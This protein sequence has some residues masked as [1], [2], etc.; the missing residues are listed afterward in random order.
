[1]AL[2]SPDRW[3]ERRPSTRRRSCFKSPR[4][5]LTCRTV[6]ADPPP[7]RTNPLHHGI[8]R[9]KLGS[10]RKVAPVP[11]GSPSASCAS[12]EATRR[13]T[14]SA[15]GA[16]S[17]ARRPPIRRCLAKHRCR[18]PEASM[19]WDRSRQPP[20]QRHSRW[21]NRPSSRA[22]RW[23]AKPLRRRRR[24]RDGSNPS[25][26]RSMLVHSHAESLDTPHRAPSTPSAIQS[27]RPGRDS[28]DR[29]RLS[30]AASFVHPRPVPTR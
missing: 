30:G 11:A 1:V 6:S 16:R 17:C 19:P 5:G 13:D 9:V 21:S 18:R 28:T 2:R 10:L 26:E 3:F 14:T 20:E 12:V 7:G 25:L 23:P 29:N 27:L 4:N 22:R 24:P 8:A 15:P